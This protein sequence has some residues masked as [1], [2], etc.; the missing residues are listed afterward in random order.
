MHTTSK[1][2]RLIRVTEKEDGSTPGCRKWLA[3]EVQSF[4]EK[5]P[6][7]EVLLY[8]SLP[9]V[10]GSPWGYINR[11]TDSGAGRIEQQQKDFTKLFKSLQ[12]LT[13]EIDGPHLSIAFELSKNCK[14]WKWP[15]SSI[16]SEKARPKVVSIPRLPVPGHW[17]G[18]EPNEKGLDDSNKHG[19]VVKSIGVCLWWFSHS[20]SKP[21]YCIKTCRELHIYLDWLHPLLFSFQS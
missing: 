3:Q 14:Y 10:C 16:F 5:S 4:R 13:H 15:M 17:L 21:G 9:C 20:W 7:G 6:Q 18:R 11:L 2:C 12:K 19:R 8:A 1:G